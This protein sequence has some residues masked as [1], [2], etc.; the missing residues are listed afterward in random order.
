MEWEV[1]KKYLKFQI[2]LVSICAV[3][4]NN[5]E[6]TTSR[7]I[8]KT[9]QKITYL[10][11]LKPILDK[12]YELYKKEYLCSDPLMYL[13][14]YKRAEDKEV[15]GLISAFM[16]LGNVKQIQKS[17]GNIL[18]VLIPSPYDALMRWNNIDKLIIEKNV[19]HRFFTAPVIGSFLY[20][21][22]RILQEYGSLKKL[23]VP[24]INN[25]KNLQMS[26][27]DIRN[28]FYHLAFSY[29]GSERKLKMLFAAP[30]KGGACKRWL[31]F[32][33]WMV[34]PDDCVDTGLWTEIN[35]SMLI[36]P[37]DTHVCRIAQLLR[38]T[39]RRNPSWKMAEE[40]TENLRYLDPQDPVKYDFALTRIGMMHKNKVHD[41][42][43]TIFDTRC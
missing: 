39:R 43:K 13:H 5:K 4:V 14:Q 9:K 40:I 21:I 35:P 1:K 2:F 6:W 20:A 42:I 19:Y 33:R 18:E 11:R 28:K 15:V 8:M 31:L 38:L 10:N 36:I 24:A 32:L 3:I 41:M 30:D 16:A 37:V 29:Y 17:I 34:R 22:H 27:S 26:L 7:Y 12:Y 23:F 25:G